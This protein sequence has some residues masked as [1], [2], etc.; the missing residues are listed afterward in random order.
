MGFFLKQKSMFLVY[1]TVFFKP[2]RTYN[3]SKKHR[4]KIR[5]AFFRERVQTYLE[6]VSFPG[7][8]S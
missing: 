5:D 3:T 1:Q 8:C 6:L 7:A 2:V 4:I